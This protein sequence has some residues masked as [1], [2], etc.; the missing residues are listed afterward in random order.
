MISCGIT[1]EEMVGVSSKDLRD[2]G[3]ADHD[4]N[5][6][7]KALTDCFNPKMNR[8][9]LLHAALQLNQS[10]ETMDKFYMRIKEKITKELSKMSPGGIEELIVLVILISGCN[11]TDFRKKTLKDRLSL[12]EFL[13]MARVSKMAEQQVQ[14]FERESK[15]NAVSTQNRHSASKKKKEETSY[16]ATNERKYFCCG[17]A[18]LHPGGR[19]NCPAINSIC[20]RCNRKGHFSEFCK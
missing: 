18:F 5:K 10:S 8:I 14:A 15:V 7:R 11:Q 20:K 2:N 12:Q 1:W 16:R 3:E 4:F 6:A 9:F 19:K 13:K 17:R